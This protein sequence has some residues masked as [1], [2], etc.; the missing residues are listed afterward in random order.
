LHIT[1]E[2]QNILKKSIT[3]ELCDG[4]GNESYPESGFWPDE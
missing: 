4:K 2:K 1:N 3:E